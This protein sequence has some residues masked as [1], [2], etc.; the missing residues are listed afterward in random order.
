[1]I[2]QLTA[3]EPQASG[4]MP[5][6]SL[7]VLHTRWSRHRTGSAVPR[8]CPWHKRLWSFSAIFDICASVLPSGSAKGKLLNSRLLDR[9]P[10]IRRRIAVEVRRLNENEV[11]K[12]GGFR[13]LETDRISTGPWFQILLRALGP[14]Q[15]DIS[16]FVGCQLQRPIPRCHRVRSGLECNPASP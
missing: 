3:V 6:S 5:R 9:T 1:L 4:V 10:S 7:R 15:S 13:G 2:L 14:A 11:R 8:V 12:S 16:W